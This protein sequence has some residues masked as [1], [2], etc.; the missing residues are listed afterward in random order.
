[1]AVSNSTDG[2][3]VKISCGPYPC[4]HEQN[5]PGT[6]LSS[7]NRNEIWVENLTA[8]EVNVRYALILPLQSN[9]GVLELRYNSD[10]EQWDSDLSLLGG[11]EACH[12]HFIQK[13]R[14]TLFS[15]CIYVPVNAADS[16]MKL[17]EIVLN[18]TVLQDSTVKDQNYEIPE[19]SDFTD[20]VYASLGTHRHEQYFLFI[21]DGFIS[22]ILPLELGRG[23][24]H[25]LLDYFDSCNNFT[26]TFVHY[27]PETN[28]LIHCHCCTN[29]SCTPYGIYYDIP[30]EELVYT[31]GPGALPYPCPDYETTVLVNETSHRFSIQGE[32]YN[33][34]GNGFRKGLCSGDSSAVWFAYQ[35]NTG[36]IFATEISSGSGPRF[37]MLSENG[38]LDPN[39]S[40]ITNVS[41][42]L[43]IQQET[44]D[45]VIAKG[46]KPKN[47][48]SVQY[49]VNSSQP[50]FFALVNYPSTIQLVRSPTPV[51]SSTLLQSPTPVPSPTSLQSTTPSPTREQKATES[52]NAIYIAVCGVGMLVIVIVIATVT[53]IIIFLV[54]KRCAGGKYMHAL[55]IT[56]CAISLF[57]R[58]KSTYPIPT[59]QPATI[60]DG[61]KDVVVPM[62][63]LDPTLIAPTTVV[64]RYQARSKTE[65]QNND[66]TQKCNL[67]QHAGN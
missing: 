31:P 59:S 4:V 10:T 5:F 26:C 64:E 45:G 44:S 41:D 48:Y 21:R 51:T 63:S 2:I 47:N 39:C 15:V 22:Y 40:P 53:G 54:Y 6:N 11:I 46:T 30:Q 19:G 65:G 56:D 14:E 17:Y 42:L 7:I 27:V 60:E 32:E 50:I 37:H 38:C 16:N 55:C 8:T 34:E 12:T 25:A 52:K 20:V 36:R 18:T 61:N 1:M 49:E 43:V 13:V 66:R 3:E 58:K 29:Q 33:L 67:M 28:L 57:H 23:K 24:N 9:V 35:D 62:P